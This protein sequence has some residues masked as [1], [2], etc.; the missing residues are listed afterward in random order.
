MMGYV[1]RIK[2][3]VEILYLCLMS[4]WEKTAPID[5]HQGLLDGN[6][7]QNTQVSRMAFLLTKVAAGSENKTYK[8]LSLHSRRKDGNSYIS[9]DSSWMTEPKEL[10]S[11]WFLEGCMNLE[12]KQEILS[13]LGKIGL[14]SIFVSC[15][16]DFVAGKSVQGYFP[17]EKESSEIY[18][19]IIASEGT[20]AFDEIEDLISKNESIKMAISE[21]RKIQNETQ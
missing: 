21:L 16:D 15:A 3:T 20:K 18:A 2:D 7:E 10:S 9:Q 12:Q 13:K 17:T 19:Q 1:M 14:S 5:R 11:G 6:L 4:R 8:T